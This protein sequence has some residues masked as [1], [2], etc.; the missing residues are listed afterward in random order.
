MNN[1]YVGVMYLEFAPFWI[2]KFTDIKCSRRTCKGLVGAIFPGTGEADVEVDNIQPHQNSG[3]NDSTKN[4]LSCQKT[5][6]WRYKH[7]KLFLS[8]NVLEQSSEKN[9]YKHNIV[10]LTAWPLRPN[11]DLS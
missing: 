7:L 2:S 3:Y 10:G 1:I 11:V 5:T 4:L 8:L 9:A 6:N